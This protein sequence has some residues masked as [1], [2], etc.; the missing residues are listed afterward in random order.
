MVRNGSSK[1]VRTAIVATLT[2][3][4]L[5]CAALA[6]DSAERRVRRHFGIPFYQPLTQANIQR[7]V[8]RVL[9]L[10]TSQEAVMVY[11]E[12]HGL[13]DHRLRGTY[14]RPRWSTYD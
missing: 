7:A 13:V 11:L 4:L 3:M 9:P 14:G 2:A 8:L 12:T 1:F 6:S 5:G 10:G